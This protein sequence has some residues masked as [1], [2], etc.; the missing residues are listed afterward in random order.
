MKEGNK[1]MHIWFLVL[2]L[3]I[4][5]EFNAVAQKLDNLNSKADDL[6]EMFVDLLKERK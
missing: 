2:L 6:Y 5:I 4:I 3:T 1:G